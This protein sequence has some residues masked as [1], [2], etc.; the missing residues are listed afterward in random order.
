VDT[1]ANAVYSWYK[2]RS[3]TDSTLLTNDLSYH[4]PFMQ[5]SDIGT[6]VCKL[7]VNDEC[8]TRL[9]YFELTGDCGHVTLPAPVKLQ[10]RKLNDANELNWESKDPLAKEFVI[11]R[12]S[13]QAPGFNTIGIVKANGTGR[14]SFTERQVTGSN[15]Q[16]RV[17]TISRHGGYSNIITLSG[18]N[19]RLSVYPNPVKQQFFISEAVKGT[20]YDVMLINSSGQVISSD[21][22]K[23]KERQQYIYNRT[24]AVKAGMYLLKIVN[25]VDGTTTVHKLVFE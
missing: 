11:E 15:N 13:A 7:S 1:I 6:Y 14:Y 9:S 10:G 24:S 8:L 2:K 19:T 23:T 21:L 5:P 20:L 22:W 18:S 12:K 3:A 4:I 17:K 16:Y 25:K